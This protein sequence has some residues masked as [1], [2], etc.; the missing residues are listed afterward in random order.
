MD[1][2]LSEM[3]Y[4]RAQSIG[5]DPLCERS[6]NEMKCRQ[7]IDALMKIAHFTMRRVHRSLL[8][9]THSPALHCIA[10]VLNFGHA[11]LTIPPY[12]LFYYVIIN[13]GVIV[14]LLLHNCSRFQKVCQNPCICNCDAQA[15]KTLKYLCTQHTHHFHGTWHFLVVFFGSYITCAK[16]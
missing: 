5:R 9:P 7:T 16:S 1:I 8:T 4:K 3:Q 11:I 6:Q 10:I 15:N 2:E 14:F 13:V 12:V